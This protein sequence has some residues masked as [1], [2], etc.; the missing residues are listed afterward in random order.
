MSHFTIYSRS[1]PDLQR[2]AR[3]ADRARSTLL[4]RWLRRL[5]RARPDDDRAGAVGTRRGKAPR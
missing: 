5:V 1:R 2:L 3:R 4:R